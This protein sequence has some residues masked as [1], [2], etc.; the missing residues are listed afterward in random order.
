MTDLDEPRYRIREHDGKRVRIIDSLSYAGREGWVLAA[1]NWGMVEIQ[2]DRRDPEGPWYYKSDLQYVELL[3]DFTQETFEA[4]MA[5]SRDFD[6][7]TNRLFWLEEM[8]ERRAGRG[9]RRF[10]EE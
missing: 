2:L 4:W 1:D 9:R 7:W 3:P 6:E 5:E 10:S 8:T